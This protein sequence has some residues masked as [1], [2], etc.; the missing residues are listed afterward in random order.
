MD[1]VRW[2]FPE[3]LDEA[4]DLLKGEGTIP[5]AGGTGIMRAGVKEGKTLVDLSRLPLNYFHINDGTVEMGAMLTYGDVAE[6]MKSVDPDSVLI[7]SLG[8][9]PVPLQ[10]RITVGGSVAFFPAWSDV[11]GPL[12]ALDAE[13]TLFGKNAGA[14]HI[15]NFAKDRALRDA[16]LIKGIRFKSERWKSHYYRAARTHFDYSAFNITILLKMRA[17]TTV[18]DVRVVVV[19]GK[20]KLKRL[21]DVEAAV[22][23]QRA[24]AIRVADLAGSADVEFHS[25]KLGSGDYLRHLARVELERGLENVLKE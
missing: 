23:G 6:R 22:K 19:G 10:D 2:C 9:L 3:T 4:V 15:A 1:R 7:K 21:N 13:V 11:M 14:Y 18:D 8:A 25:K 20:E 16:T 5:H 17:D 12:V 24:A